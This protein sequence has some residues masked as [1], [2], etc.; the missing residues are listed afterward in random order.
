MKESLV[1]SLP[2]SKKL[3]E[4]GFKM[5]SEYYWASFRNE[6][7]PKDQWANIYHIVLTIEEIEEH[8][9]RDFLK[10]FEYYPAYLAGELA[11]ALPWLI[12]DGKSSYYLI[13]ERNSIGGKFNIYYEFV[14]FDGGENHNLTSLLK[15]APSLAEAMG[16]MVVFLIEKD[17]I[18]IKKL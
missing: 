15:K 14:G 12:E 10:D 16:L 2:L 3:Q 17:I 7:S 4:L 8:Q 11:E 5:E 1:T 6:S 13:I 18:N 9:D